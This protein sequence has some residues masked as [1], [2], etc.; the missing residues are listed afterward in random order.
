MSATQ[1][2]EFA[3]ARVTVM[4]LGLFGGGAAV[5]RHFARRGAQVIVTDLRGAD[6]L[7]TALREVADLDLCLVLGEHRE[8]DFT[9]ASI[10]VANPAV[11]PTNRYLE[12]AR[13]SGARVTSEVALFLDAC[14][15]QV[16][17]ITGTQ[18]KSS[19]CSFLAQ[20]LAAGERSVHLGGN[21]GR[22]L[23]AEVEHMAPGD[24]VVLELS[25]YQ[26]ESLPDELTRPREAS[27]IGLAA[28]VNVLSDHL[29]RHGTR[30]AYARAKLRLAEL[31]RPA[32]ALL[33]PA[34]SLPVELEAPRDLRLL[35]HGTQGVRIEG[36]AF[37]GADEVLG[38]VCD[39]PFQAPFQLENVALALGLARLA[40]LSPEVLAGALPDLHGLPHRLDPV[41]QLDGRP[42]WDNGV[43][44]T[45]DS[46]V[47]ALEALPPGV[48]L[49]VG[50][51]VKRL[52][53]AP[54]IEACRRREA[55][56]VVFGAAREAWPQAFA[57]AGLEAGAAT[58][59][60]QALDQ[61]RELAGSSILFSPACSSFDAYP[62]FKARAEEFLAHARRS[63]LAPRRER[64]Q[65]A[66][67][68]RN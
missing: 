68:A 46:T 16:I 25:S 48:I 60:A 13:R 47:S 35:R 62:N 30:E 37:H 21:I 17:A 5:A 42:L 31:V 51:Q 52:D 59:P 57:A 54:L 34:D 49:L 64:A 39:C 63:G 11:R 24:L 15:G 1:P 33:L 10:V 8:E 7:E 66:R 56:V 14:P 12:L 18:G 38:N 55:Q 40:G 58:G 3:R 53:L 44:T 43:S 4:G 67:A 32:G 28:I 45:P 2:D 9:R 23:L 36:G 26:L 27:P 61:A 29:E 41:G 19:T 50:G 65:G 6:E 20:M 22:P